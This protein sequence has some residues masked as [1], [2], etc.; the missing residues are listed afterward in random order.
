MN[1]KN[2][3]GRKHR[4]SWLR[5][6]ATFSIIAAVAVSAAGST[7]WAADALYVLTRA[8]DAAIV[9]DSEDQISSVS[10]K[11]VQFSGE[12]DSFDIQLEEGAFV[13]LIH[14]DDI[15]STEA[16]DER[17]SALLARLHVNPS[18]LEMVSVDRSNPA[19]P[20]IT[21]GEEITF[22][23]REETPTT[24]AT[25]RR[26]S[27]TLPEGTEQVVQQG[28]DG[29]STSVYEVV[30]SHGEFLS[31]Q[32]VETVDNTAVDEI[33][34]YSVAD[35]NT[36]EALAQAEIAKTAAQEAEAAVKAASAAKAQAAAEKA[37][38]AANAA[39]AAAAKAIPYKQETA[40]KAA[41][42]AANAAVAAQEAVPAAK[43][44]EEEKAA[45]EARKAE[46]AK[47]AAE[48]AK[49]AEQ[50]KVESTKNLPMD[51]LVKVNP[52]S[53]GS[54]GTLVFKSGRVVRYKYAKKMTA[55]AYNKDEPGL[56]VITATGTHVRKGVVAVDKR[57]IPLGTR[58][59]VVANGYEYGYS[60]AEDTGVVGNVIDLYFESYK[61]MINFGRRS[62][63]I[64]VLE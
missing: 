49:K 31:R 61:G 8:E 10:S 27:E 64:Y 56:G 47:K 50:S 54:G 60:V 1:G 36:D 38:N 16:R 55:T 5:G 4:L 42:D 58:M 25:V 13:T 48:A 12:A 53:S 59:Y 32:L 18:P 15:L 46:E 41:A 28:S 24:Y 26:P 23:E 39:A 29:V 22:Y 52:S 3:R 21:V 11:L 43:K 34:E 37:Q 51:T 35:H 7:G 14:G 9:L 44:A 40:A 17:V 45:E 33:V 20:V 62:C 63:T 57:V 6:A 19:H 2:T 30:W